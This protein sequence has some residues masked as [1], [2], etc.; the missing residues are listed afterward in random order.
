MIGV[1]TVLAHNNWSVTAFTDGVGFTV[2]VKLLG[3]PLQLNVSAGSKIWGV[4]VI[5]AV[6]GDAVV[7]VA[8]NDG[9]L[10]EPKAARPILGSLLSH[11]YCMIPPLFG[12]LKLITGVDNPLQKTWSGTGFTVAV[13][14]TKIVNESAV[15]VQL[16]PALV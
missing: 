2:I 12:L 1:V 11:P 7:F 13:G 10:P 6:T 8:V 16:T 14:N 5:M 4:T 15:P 9:K 3:V